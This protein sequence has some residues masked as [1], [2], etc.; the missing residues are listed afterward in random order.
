MQLIEMS[1]G[2]T[3]TIDVFAWA[4][5]HILISFL[6]ERVPASY[7]RQDSFF[8]HSLLWEDN[9]EIWER[10][11]RVK[12]W[13]HLIMDGTIIIQKGFEKKRLAS[14]K[15]EYLERF[16]QESRRAELTHWISIL[17]APLFFLWNPV[18]AGWIMIA[19]AC[20]FN[21][22]IIIAQRYNRPRLI[23]ILQR[24]ARILAKE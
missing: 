7:F 23:K 24:K 14:N 19:Y 18:W 16:L 1:A 13:K 11:F 4:F 9:G 21:G 5:F 3:L 2:W 8:L 10:L 6:M 20:L 12:R 17:P 15:R 22:P